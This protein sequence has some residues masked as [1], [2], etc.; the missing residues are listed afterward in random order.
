VQVTKSKAFRG[1]QR[2]ERATVNK[3]QTPATPAIPDVCPVVD[4]FYK[5]YSWA[6]ANEVARLAERGATLLRTRRRIHA[7]MVP[8]QMQHLLEGAIAGRSGNGMPHRNE[9]MDNPAGCLTFDFI[10]TELRP[11]FTAVIR[12]CLRPTP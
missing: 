1:G 4:E 6:S 10:R 8:S 3:E 2:R 7:V 12:D 11:V 9:T 5:R